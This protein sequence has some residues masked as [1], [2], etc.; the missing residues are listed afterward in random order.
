M[1]DDTIDAVYLATPVREHLPQTILAAAAGKHVLVEKPMA[2]T[3]NECDEMIAACA[4]ANVQ[5]GVAYYRRFYPIVE[6]IKELLQTQKI[7]DPLCVSAV[8]S[9]PLAMTESDDGYWRTN[10]TDSGGGA[11]M[12]V[13]SHRI[14]V[15]LHLFGPVKTVK[16]ICTRV[17]AKYETEDAA[18][19]IMQ[20]ESGL[21]GTLQC[22]FGANDPDEF[23]ILGTKGRFIASPLNGD[24]LIIEIDGKQTAETLPSAKNFCA[25]LIADFV[26]A[27]HQNRPP[28]IDGNE[29]RATSQLMDQAYADSV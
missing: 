12:D 11:L 5:L 16:A 9:T 1:H 15:F 20:F 7:G 3:A 4:E 24:K 18:V 10:Q 21:V 27:I 19:L 23:T 2:I 29:G 13:G 26:Q 6:R 17:A 25:P 8:T 28:R 14:N 22:H